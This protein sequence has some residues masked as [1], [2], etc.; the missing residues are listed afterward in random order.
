MNITCD[1]D[2]G[3]GSGRELGV[4]AELLHSVDIASTAWRRGTGPYAWRGLRDQKD[5]SV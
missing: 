5:Q 2:V 3:R 4:D 1:S